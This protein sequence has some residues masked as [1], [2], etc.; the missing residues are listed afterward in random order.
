MKITCA[1]RS[2]E[3]IIK[4]RDEYDARKKDL[5]EQADK[6]R[7]NYRK[8][9]YSVFDS[10]KAQVESQL[11]QFE[12]LNLEVNVESG[13]GNGVQVRI[14]SNQHNVFSEHKALSW[15]YKVMLD[16]EGKVKRETGSWSGLQ[17]VTEEQVESLRQSVACFEILNSMD[18]ETIVNTP[19]PDADEYVTV[20]TYDVDRNRPNY[21][22]ELLEA[23]IDEAIQHGDWIKG[24]GYKI[25][26]KRSTVYY[27]VL[28]ETPKMYE[29]VEV[30]EGRMAERDQYSYPYK[31]AKDVFF[32]VIDRPIEVYEG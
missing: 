22:Q 31:I 10:V 18:W 16:K 6:Q 11:S 13:W 1:K 12:S 29:V 8:A 26:Q 32:Q 14:G 24:N 2:R 20:N 28:K 15:D 21:E 25:Y 9:L 30:W 23:E 17:A 3:E 5:H 4:D 27:K 7:S 19:T